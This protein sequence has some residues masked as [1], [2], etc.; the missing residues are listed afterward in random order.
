MN[1][2]GPNSLAVVMGDVHAHLALAAAALARIEAERGRPVAQVFSVGDLGLFVDAEDWRW[3]AGPKKHRHP[4]WSTSIARSWAAWRWPL[5]TIAGNHEPFG[6]LR[7]W[8]AGHFGGKLL[9]T[10]A[11]ELA[12]TLP[13]LRVCGL[14]GI[15][16][17]EHLGFHAPEERC[18]PERPRDW[19]ALVAAVAAGRASARRLCYHKQDELDHLRSLPAHPHLLLTHDWPAWPAGVQPPS[20]AHADKPEAMLLKALRPA[21]HLCGHHHRP[22]AFRVGATEVRALNILSTGEDAP[23]RARRPRVAP[24]WAALFGWTPP[25]ETTDE[26]GRLVELGFWPPLPTRPSSP[27][28][29]RP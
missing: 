15:F 26:E 5:S 27:L 2:P 22:A 4:E 18:A 17:P 29:S 25:S 28:P 3:F 11:G 8:D 7:A 6:S 24:G 23:G 21:F 1:D 13:G 20:P 14:S 19:P 9:Y 16:H 12:H 10:D